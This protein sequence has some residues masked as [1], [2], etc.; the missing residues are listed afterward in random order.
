VVGARVS[1]RDDDKDSTR[2]VSHLAQIEEGE[3]WAKSHGYEIVGRFEDLGISAGKTTPFE[4]PDLGKWLAPERLQDFDVLVFAKIDRAFRSTIDSA[5]NVTVPMICV[6]FAKW[7]KANR[8]I[9]AFVAG[10]RPAGSCTPTSDAGK[11][12][13]IIDGESE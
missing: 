3:R 11:P 1:H 4:R 12:R 9:L 2:K 13:T 8:K 5:P 10:S 6:E 7:T